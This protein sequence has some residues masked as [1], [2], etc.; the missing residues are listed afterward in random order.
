MEL[1]YLSQGASDDPRR[2]R[3]CMRAGAPPAVLAK[4]L[5]E[6]SGTPRT[7]RRHPRRKSA[8]CLHWWEVRSWSPP[9]VGGVRHTGSPRWRRLGPYSGHH[10]VRCSLRRCALESG[11]RGL[12]S[13]FRFYWSAH[14]DIRCA[15]V[16]SRVRDHSICQRG[17]AV[18]HQ[19]G[20]DYWM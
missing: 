19:Y 2:I 17:Y 13:F 11:S 8:C 15:L 4:P 14:C 18:N 10:L 9:S 6:S 1:G 12:G 16:R 3:S 5:V 7:V 20:G